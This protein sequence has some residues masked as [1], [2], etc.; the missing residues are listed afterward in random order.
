MY[1]DA[2]NFQSEDNFNVPTQITYEITIFFF[3]WLYWI[4][5]AIYIVEY[6]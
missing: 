2:R 1:F 3:S 4:N 5:H 6:I